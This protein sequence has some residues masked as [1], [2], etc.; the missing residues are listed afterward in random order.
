MRKAIVAIM[1]DTAAEAS[2]SLIDPAKIGGAVSSTYLAVS[3][4]VPPLVAVGLNAGISALYS[5][6]KRYKLQVAINDIKRERAAGA[7]TKTAGAAEHV[8]A[9]PEYRRILMQ[10]LDRAGLTPSRYYHPVIVAHIL[11]D[12][13]SAVTPISDYD[14][15]LLDAVASMT[16]SELTELKYWFTKLDPKRTKRWSGYIDTKPE[17]PLSDSQRPFLP[18]DLGSFAVKLANCGLISISS[19]LDRNRSRY[20]EHQDTISYEHTITILSQVERLVAIIQAIDKT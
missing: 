12:H 20:E 2:K 6:Y 19:A 18:F 5:G 17:Y 11:F 1:R 14:Q 9:N 4:V 13:A 15:G 3:A 7:G 8:A 16:D 10:E